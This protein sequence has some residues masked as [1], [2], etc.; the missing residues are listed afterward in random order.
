VKIV[1][2]RIDGLGDAL[3]CAPLIAALRDAGHEV[4]AVLAS[5]NREAYAK[6]AFAHVHELERIPWPK[7]G[8]TK[9]SRRTALD[10]MKDARYDVALIASEEIDAYQIAKEA[11]IPRRVGFS[12]GWEKPLKTFQI[13]Q[14]LTHKILRPASANKAS[15]HEVETIFRLGEGLHGEHAPTRDVQRLGALLLDGR[16]RKSD[17][18]AVQVSGKNE[19]H[20]LDKETYVALGSQL[21]RSGFDV[22]LLGNELSLLNAVGRAA[23]VMED[24][25]LSL[26]D[27]KE[28]IAAATALVTPDSGAAHVAGMLGIPTIDCFSGSPHVNVD[29]RRWAP[30]AAPNRCLALADA[31]PDFMAGALVGELLDLL[32]LAHHG[33]R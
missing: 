15:E 2:V 16:V 5:G 21:R 14:L 1:L 12:N 33:R 30:W 11:G 26:P 4:S 13:G 24:P 22:M 8:S 23:N 32:E 18:V 31:P 28:R 3:V 20:G 9:E 29:M 10:E 7:H 19:S 27:W 6:R 17:Y 25:L